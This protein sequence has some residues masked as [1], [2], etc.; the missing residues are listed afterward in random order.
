MG[1]VLF[2]LSSPLLLTSC[3]S[4]ASTF[5]PRIKARITGVQPT[6]SKQTIKRY[7]DAAPV[8]T[9][10]WHHADLRVPLPPLDE[11]HAQEHPI[12]VRDGLKVYLCT[13]EAAVH[14]HKVELSNEFSKH[15]GTAVYVCYA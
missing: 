1:C 14:Y 4:A 10:G 3:R 2:V 13:A 9:F 8:S 12:G 15:Y 5:G 7:L 11:L 6:L